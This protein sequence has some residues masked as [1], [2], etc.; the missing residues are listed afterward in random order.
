MGHALTVSIQCFTANPTP[1]WGDQ[2]MGMDVRGCSYSVSLECGNS[3]RFC[4]PLATEGYTEV[5]DGSE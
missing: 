4:K 3:T 2:R 5:L 1:A